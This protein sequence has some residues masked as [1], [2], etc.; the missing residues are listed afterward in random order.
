M[1][2]RRIDGAAAV[3]GASN[4]VVVDVL[5]T[6]GVSSVTPLDIVAV[7]TAGQCLACRYVSS[8]L[9]TWVVFVFL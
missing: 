8:Y 3:S 5:V 7:A 2:T 1:K 6:G 9:T 4:A